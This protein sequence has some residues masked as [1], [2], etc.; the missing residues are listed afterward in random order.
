M[1]RL[2]MGSFPAQLVVRKAEI[3]R[4]ADQPHAGFQLRDLVCGM[5]TATSQTGQALARR[6]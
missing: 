5:S 4:A 2:H 6:A 3:V 1:T